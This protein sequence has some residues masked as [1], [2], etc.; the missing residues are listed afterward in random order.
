M[1]MNTNNI[2]TVETNKT[3]TREQ[4]SWA[5]LQHEQRRVTKIAHWHTK[6]FEN[7]E[8]RQLCQSGYNKMSEHIANKTQSVRANNDKKWSTSTRL[9]ETMRHQ[10][11]N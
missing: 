8:G 4:Y 6:Q 10:G 9:S 1:K 2:S 3:K 7:R 11:L 5:I